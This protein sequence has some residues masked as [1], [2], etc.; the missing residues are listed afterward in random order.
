MSNTKFDN[1]TK[2]ST[3]LIIIATVFG[4][5]SSFLAPNIP[6]KS[7]IEVVT[8]YPNGKK[9]A[10]ESLPTTNIVIGSN[11]STIS[12][13]T[14]SKISYIDTS[15]TKKNSNSNSNSNS[16]G[17]VFSV[18]NTL[19]NINNSQDSDGFNAGYVISDQDLYSLPSNLNSPEKIRQFLK[20]KGSFLAD[21]QVD[22]NFE[23]DDDMANSSLV[24]S[25]IASQLGTK[26]S[27]ADLVWKLSR[28][29][30]GSSCSITNPNL[31]IDIVSKPINPAFILSLIQRESGL[32]YGKNAKLDPNSDE[33]KF[34]IDR[35][36]GYYC[37]ESSEKAQTC[38]DQNPDWKY[39]KGLFRQVYYGTRMVLLNSKKCEKNTGWFGGNYKVGGVV[40]VDNQDIKLENALACSLYV[41]TPHISA[42]RSVYKIFREING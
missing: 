18:F 28:T 7:A 4:S 38:Y 12:T 16:V 33:A 10:E 27:F 35:A 8:I 23:N 34:L 13:T 14:G 32:I 1:T 21:Y 29:N 41:Y 3:I 9:P 20:N 17:S 5:V 39:Y 30:F 36:T 25:N 11:N 42:Q 22:I 19:K 15:T 40:T 26:I 37:L 31:C 2:L 6:V 24:K